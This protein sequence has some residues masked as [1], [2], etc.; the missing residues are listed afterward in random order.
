MQN[1]KP[2]TRNLPEYLLI[3]A[4]LFYWVSTAFLLNPVAIGLLAVLV[5]QLFL[6]SR[7]IGIV[8]PGLLILASFYMLLAMMSELSEFPAFNA[9]ARK[10]L[11]V[12]LSFFLSTMVISGWMIY[13]YASP[14]PL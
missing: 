14:K 13:K 4:V 2:R 3:A 10:L 8:I 6:K 7:V 11:V 1:L 5:L 9:D 12:G